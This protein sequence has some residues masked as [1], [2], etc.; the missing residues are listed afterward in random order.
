MS[1][2]TLRLD[3]ESGIATITLDRPDA[4]NALNIGLVATCCM[5]RSRQTRTGRCAAS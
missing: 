5:R 1:Y 4:Y 2:E 3:V